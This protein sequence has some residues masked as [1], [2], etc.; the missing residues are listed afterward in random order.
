MATPNPLAHTLHAVGDV[1]LVNYGSGGVGSE[2]IAN[3]LGVGPMHDCLDCAYEEFFLTSSAVG[4]PA[5][6][7]DIPANFGLEACAPSGA[8]CPAR[9]HRARRP[10]RAF[11]PDDPSN[12]HHSYIGDHVKFRNLHTGKEHHIFHLHNHQ[13]LFNP[14]DDN[15]NYID[16][17][18]IGPGGGYTY[19]INFGGS[20]NRNKSAGDAIFHCHFYPHFAQGMWDLWRIHDVL[21][22]GTPLA[23]AARG[24]FHTTPFALQDGTPRADRPASARPRPARR[25][26]RRRHADPGG[27]SAARQGHG[28][29]CPAGS[30]VVPKVVERHRPSG[31]AA[32]RRRVRVS[33]HRLRLGRSRPSACVDPD[34]RRTAGAE[35]DRIRNPG[36]P[37]WI[38]GVEDTIGQRTPTPPLD[39]APAAGGWDGGLPRHALDGS[40]VGLHDRAD[41][42]AG[43]AIGRAQRVASRLDEGDQEGQGRSCSRRTGPT[44][45]RPP[46]P[47]TPSASIP[48]PSPCSTARTTPAAS[49][50]TARRPGPR[51]AVPRALHR[52]HGAR[53]SPPAHRQLLRRQRAAPA[54]PAARPSTP[55]DAA[56]LQGRQHP[57]RRGAQQARL[58]L[59]AGAHHRAVGGRGPDHQQEASRPSRW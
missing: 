13:W 54:S 32:K 40:R 20:G 1:F 15:S 24:G 9:R 42:P 4:D 18:G 11:Y 39:M 26:N 16:A 22:T 29:R 52:R 30:P 14:N 2:I 53:S 48:A 44:W 37:F 51:R 35:P 12:V 36:F 23:G 38:A 17:Q 28:A 56:R 10:Q 43:A 6:L 55:I 49:S 59:P 50:P 27:G 47:S 58:P 31:S 7:V 5:M 19:E 21:E 25:R 3:R 45:S 8:V 34:E 57:V 46:W 33:R 41:A